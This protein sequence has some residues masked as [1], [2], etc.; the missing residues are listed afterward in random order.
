MVGERI[1][2][3]NERGTFYVFGTDPKTFQLL[4]KNPLGDQ[5]FDTPVIVD[6]QIFARVNHLDGGKRQE[7]LSCLETK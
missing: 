6:S 7:K 4:A 1:Y 3:G 5:V 2:V